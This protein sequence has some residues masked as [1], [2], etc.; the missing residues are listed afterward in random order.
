MGVGNDA[1]HN[2]LVIVQPDVA[3]DWRKGVV[4]KLN[5]F[6]GG[7]FVVG[8]EDMVPLPFLCTSSNESL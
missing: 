3:D 1:L 4:Q 6:T 5:D 2:V 8:N 7:I